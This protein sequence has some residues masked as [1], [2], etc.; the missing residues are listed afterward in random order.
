MKIVKVKMS[1]K[2]VFYKTN[3]NEKELLKVEYQL[4][5]IPFEEIQNYLDNNDNFKRIESKLNSYDYIISLLDDEYIDLCENFPH[6][7]K[8]IKELEQLIQT[9]D[10]IIGA[11]L[12][13]YDSTKSAKPIC[14]NEFEIMPWYYDDVAWVDKTKENIILFFAIY[15]NKRE[16]IL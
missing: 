3:L 5:D 7:K 15:S 14:V 2:E 10:N 16:L 6:D 9:R 12:E 1:E 4:K 11:I 8:R 13:M